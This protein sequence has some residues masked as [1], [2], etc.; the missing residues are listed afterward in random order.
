MKLVK[1]NDPILLKPTELFNFENPQV[2]PVELIKTMNEIYD[3]PYTYLIGWSKLDKWYYGVRY[4][5][6]CNPNDLWNPYKTSSKHVKNFIEENGEPDV[7]KIKRTFKDANSAIIWESKVLKRM[8]VIYNDKWLNKTD[9]EAIYNEYSP[10]KGK[11]RDDIKGLNNPSKRQKSREK[12]SQFHKN[13][14]KNYNVWNKGKKGLQ[15]PWN[16][17]LTKED[18]SR[19]ISGENHPMKKNKELAKRVSSKRIGIKFT[20]SRKANISNS[21]KGMVY[22]KDI[23]GNMFYI[24]KSEFDKRKGIDLFGRT[25]KGAK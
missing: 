14:P 2:D 21:K 24:P 15:I 23:Q 9:N 11:V 22:C 12:I 17:G 13:K 25:Y 20:E 16:K 8:K 4:A 1:S 3:I 19:I 7:I 10:M 6:G 18:D 5:K